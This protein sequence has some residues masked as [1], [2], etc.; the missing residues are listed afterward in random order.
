MAVLLLSCGIALVRA[1]YSINQGTQST[2]FAFTCFAVK[3][4][5]THV[6]VNSS[7]VEIGTPTSPL[8]VGPTAVTTTTNPGTV[9]VTGVF[10]SILAA[11]PTRYGCVVQNQSN[12]ILYI[13]FGANASATEASSLTIGPGGSIPCNLPGGVV[14]TDNV[15]VAGMAGDAYVVNNQ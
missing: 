2:I 4:C 14:L 12:D 1:D 5:P 7:G 8:R 15:S 11:N 10:Q 3:I 13:F 9:T 6:N